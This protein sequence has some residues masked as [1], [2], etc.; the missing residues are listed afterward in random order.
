MCG[1][2]SNCPGGYFCG[3]TN[4][5]PN[6]GATNFD[7]FMY[8]LLVVFQ[9]VTLEGWS[10]TQRMLQLTYSYYI[11]IYFLPLVFIGAFFLLNLTLAVINAKFN[12]A[13]KAQQQKEQEEQ[14]RFMNAIDR[15]DGG[16]FKDDGANLCELRDDL[17]IYQY[18]TAQKYA[19]LMIKFL[20]ARRR[21]RA[22][23]EQALAEAQGR[24][25]SLNVNYTMSASE[26]R[27]QDK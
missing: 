10:E 24:K 21:E 19:K 11:F 7:N 27:K 17:S 25:I 1:G 13:H 22:E 23:R 18:I 8:S 14:Q 16:V 9:S 12:E 3:K 2:Q 26:K 4:E 20:N 15:D 5:N 6:N